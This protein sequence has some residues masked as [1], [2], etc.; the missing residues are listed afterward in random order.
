MKNGKGAITQQKIVVF[1]RNIKK[2][3][4]N[5]NIRN[6][7]ITFKILRSLISRGDTLKEKQAYKIIWALLVQKI[8][9]EFLPL[10]CLCAN[11]FMPIIYILLKIIM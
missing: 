2:S 5:R 6:V 1:F 8:S 4:L 3:F 10:T 11:I 9:F 7:I